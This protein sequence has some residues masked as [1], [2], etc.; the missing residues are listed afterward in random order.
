LPR[1]R[2]GVD[3]ESDAPGAGALAERGRGVVVR[4]DLTLNRGDVVE[5]DR[6]A[7]FRLG[8]RTTFPGLEYGIEGMRVGGRRRFR[9]GPHLAY[10][11]R[12]VPDR[13]P[14]GAVLVV[15]AELLEVRRTVGG[16][17]G[18]G[19]WWTCAI[20]SGPED[21]QS[22][23]SVPTRAPEDTLGDV[24]AFFDSHRAR[25]DALGVACFG[26][27]DLDATSPTFGRVTT[28]P[29]PGWQHADV[30]RPLRERLSV[31]V[32]FDTDVNGAALGEHRWGAGRDL[33]P[34]VYVTVGTGIGAGAIVNGRLLHGLAHPEMGHAR[35][36]HDR[37]ADPFPGC[38]PHH[39]DCLEG[40]ASGVALAGRWG[41]PAE[42]LPEDH[43]G[44]DLQA[45]YLAL[46]MVGI[47]TVLSPRRIVLAGGVMRNSRLLPRVRREVATLLAGYV[48]T[49]DIVPPGLGERS[50]V[51]GA[52]A[53]AQAV[54]EGADAAAA[55]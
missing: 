27:V 51:L 19:T 15:D 21:V 2:G 33:D 3:I 12:G 53:L 8:A 22:Q 9:V 29:K 40:L 45:R 50:G 13:I 5:R 39:G 11:D 34:F 23:R 54:L 46:G 35:I 26:P 47:I 4:Y 32:A 20:G 37:A 14:P 18:G 38:C 44:W 16:V 30:A 55:S 43:P 24:A 52:M 25:I 48:P 41:M 1:S 10:G 28:T 31:P 36:P 42:Q 6:V 49:A 7:V 17:E